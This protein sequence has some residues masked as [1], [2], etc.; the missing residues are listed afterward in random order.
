LTAPVKSSR[1]LMALFIQDAA[2]DGETTILESP[3]VAKQ[4]RWH[5][6][7]PE[8]ELLPPQKESALRFLY[9][10]EHVAFRASV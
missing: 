8:W 9:S 1:A 5:R 3:E 2:G 4:Y 7:G 6:F 10:L